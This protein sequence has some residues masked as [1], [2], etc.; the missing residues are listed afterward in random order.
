MR[1]VL[2]RTVVGSCDGH[3]NNLSRSYHDQGQSLLHVHVGSITGFQKEEI[4]VIAL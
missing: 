3:L 2:R 1:L 4:K